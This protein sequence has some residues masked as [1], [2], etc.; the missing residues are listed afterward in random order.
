MHVIGTPHQCM[1]FVFLLPVADEFGRVRLR[2]G[3]TPGSDYINASFI[4]VCFIL[5]PTFYVTILLHTQIYPLVASIA[6]I[7]VHVY[8]SVT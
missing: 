4:H 5:L 7:P 1:R 2:Q 6:P 8:L 3:Y